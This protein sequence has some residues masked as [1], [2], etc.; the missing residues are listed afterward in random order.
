MFICAKNLPLSSLIF[1]LVVL[2]P[3]DKKLTIFFESFCHILL[4]SNVYFSVLCSLEKLCPKIEPKNLKNTLFFWQF[5]SITGSSVSISKI[6]GACPKM[7][8]RNT[9]HIRTGCS[10]KILS[11]FA[12]KFCFFSDWKMT[13]PWR[14][15]SGNNVCAIRTIL[16]AALSRNAIPIWLAGD[17]K[18]FFICF[19]LTISVPSHFRDP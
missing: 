11:R 9:L 2:F 15:V 1:P 5:L 3:C 8:F 17:R 16:A 19:F 10:R 14:L 7:L 6:P 13:F 18:D 4:L 12:S